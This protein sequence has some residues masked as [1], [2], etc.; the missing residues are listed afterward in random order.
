[1]SLSPSGLV[2]DLWTARTLALETQSQNTEKY[3]NDTFLNFPR[4]GRVYQYHPRWTGE[5]VIHYIDVLRH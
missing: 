3:L 2:H 5:K 4:D 1:M